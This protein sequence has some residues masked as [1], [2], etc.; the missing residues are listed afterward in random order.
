M[1]K[2]LEDLYQNGV[3]TGREQ[4]IEQGV[5]RGRL[6]GIRALVET[7]RELGQTQETAGQKVA[8]KFSV[9]PEQAEEY[10]AAYWGKN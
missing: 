10:A 1:C 7:C 6:Q 9:P 5:E 4:G 2:A 3:D 8:E